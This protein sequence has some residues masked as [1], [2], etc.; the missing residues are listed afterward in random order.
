MSLKF[1]Y[2]VTPV[3]ISR[4]LLNLRQV[5]QSRGGLSNMN[6]S[7]VGSVYFNIPEGV[8][9]NLGESLQ[10]GDDVGHEEETHTVQDIGL[11]AQAPNHATDA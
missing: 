5:D 4:F 2:S 8:F 11:V 3:L 9:G 6:T 7:R 1:V 10:V